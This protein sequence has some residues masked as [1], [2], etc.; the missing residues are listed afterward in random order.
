MTWSLSSST[1]ARS[2]STAMTSAPEAARLRARREPKR[3]KPMTANRSIWS[4]DSGELGVVV[5][6]VGCWCRD[7]EGETPDFGMR[8]ANRLLSLRIEG[9]LDAYEDRICGRRE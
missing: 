1:I 5:R 4:E 2:L 3:P 9:G 6:F 8:L 7:V